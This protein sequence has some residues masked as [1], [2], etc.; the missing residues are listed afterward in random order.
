MSAAFTLEPFED[1]SQCGFPGCIAHAFHEG[2]HEFAPKAKPELARV[3]HCVVCGSLFKYFA[4]LN[5]PVPQTCGEQ[6]C[7]VHFGSHSAEPSPLRCSCPQR[8]YAHDVSIHTKLRGESYN[9][10]VRYTY[11]WSLCL[12][13]RVEPSTEREAAA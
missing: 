9:P 13:E 4:P 10:K 3:F 5:H 7:L 8:P 1:L 11:P 12:A 2:G 6:A